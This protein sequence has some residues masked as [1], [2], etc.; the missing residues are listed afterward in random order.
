MVL[1]ETQQNTYQDLINKLKSDESIILKEKVHIFNDIEEFFIEYNFGLSIK[2]DYYKK[3][4]KIFI[5][6][7]ESKTTEVDKLYSVLSVI[8][9]FFQSALSH[10][11]IFKPEKIEFS[12]VK[13]KYRNSCNIIFI[14]K[15]F[16]IMFT[17]FKDNFNCTIILS[18]I[19]NNNIMNDKYILNHV[20]TFYDFLLNL[21]ISENKEIKE[22]FVINKVSN[23]ENLFEHFQEI[24][25]IERIYKY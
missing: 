19:L 3:Q 5:S 22:L 14:N 8:N 11:N 12:Y 13:Q 1:I 4:H 6:S 15:K 18:N 21:N 24:K 9:P 17:D 23:L 20:N 2:I 10:L 16:K 25:T 7:I